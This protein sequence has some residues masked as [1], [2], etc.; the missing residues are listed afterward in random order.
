M[1]LPKYIH[2]QPFLLSIIDRT[3]R[4]ASLKREFTRQLIYIYIYIYIY[5]CIYSLVKEAQKTFGGNDLDVASESGDA[6]S[7]EVTCGTCYF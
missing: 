4:R 1:K 7:E 2:G 3:I 5:I 6:R